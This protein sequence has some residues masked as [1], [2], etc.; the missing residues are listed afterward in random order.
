MIKYNG[1]DYVENIQ[2]IK[3]C[4]WFLYYNDII[5]IEQCKNLLEKWKEEKFD[6]YNYK[7]SCLELR[8]KNE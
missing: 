2:Q 7:K 6:K 8:F 4:I 3:D 1:Y 5:D